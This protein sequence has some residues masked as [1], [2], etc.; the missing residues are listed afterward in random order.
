MRKE[1]RLEGWG[2]THAQEIGTSCPHLHSLLQA[3][4]EITSSVSVLLLTG[5]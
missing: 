4:P 1:P 5:D 2:H 3:L